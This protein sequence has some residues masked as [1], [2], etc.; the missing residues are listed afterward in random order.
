MDQ[1]SYAFFYENSTQRTGHLPPRHSL[2]K[3]A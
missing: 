3:P 1:F 2:K